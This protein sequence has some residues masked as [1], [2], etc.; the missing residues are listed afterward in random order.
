[1]S[2]QVKR[3]VSGLAT[4][5]ILALWASLCVNPPSQAE[6]Q[7]KAFGLFDRDDR[8]AGEV[9]ST[10]EKLDALSTSVVSSSGLFDRL[11]GEIST[12]NEK[13]D[14][15]S[16]S[17]VS[18]SGLFER[19]SSQITDTSTATNRRIDDLTASVEKLSE[20]IRS[21]DGKRVRSDGTEFTTVCECGCPDCNCSTQVEGGV[22]TVDTLPVL[23]QGVSATPWV[24]TTTCVD[25]K[26]TTTPQQG[27]YTV[28]QQTP[29]YRTNT[30]YRVKRSGRK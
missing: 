17:V 13:L 11:S 5:T 3:T 2:T 24:V 30:A 18:S 20:D 22:K 19:I 26:C 10:N 25:G 23:A 28:Q 27:R 1:M 9:K 15:L 6:Q 14:A 7:P 29:Q 16:T 12:T 21:R 4:I 8:L